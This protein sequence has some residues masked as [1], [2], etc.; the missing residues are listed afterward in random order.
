V[1]ETQ[2]RGHN[3][4]LIVLA[5]PFLTPVSLPFVSTPFGAAI[6]LI[7]LRMS[8]GQTPGFSQR[9]LA[10]SL[11]SRFVPKLFRAGSRVLR[12]LEYFTKPRL[13]SMH[14]PAF[15]QRLSGGLI[16][17]SGILLLLPLPIPF[18]NFLPALT[19]LLLAAGSLEHDG[20]CLIAG[21]FMF[22]ATSAYFL[23]LALGG[24]Q[25]LDK[26]FEVFSR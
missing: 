21:W 24:R 6:A 5:L 11:P 17:I 20:W 3:L 25:I 19:I 18:T 26:L 8:L 13:A 7:G 4:L 16:A 1:A 15:F 10:R 23:L 12:A 14:N 2:G 9:L 22:M